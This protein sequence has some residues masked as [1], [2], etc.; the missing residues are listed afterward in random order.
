M[1]KYEYKGNELDLFEYA[2]NW[3]SYWSKQILPYIG[4][5]VLEVGAGIGSNTK[6]LNAGQ[7]KSWVCIEPDA[8]LV[9]EMRKKVCIGMLPKTLEIR[10]IS[11]NE[12][13]INEKFDTILY[14]DVL[15]HIKDDKFELERAFQ[16]LAPKGNIIILSPAHNFLY[17]EFDR[18]IE[19]YRRYNKKMLR[20]IIPDGIRIKLMRYIDAVGLF[21][22]LANKL[23]LRSA[24]PTLTQIKI[25]DSFM[26]TISRFVDP[27]LRH[28]FGKSI[29]CIIGGDKNEQPVAG[30]GIS[31]NGVI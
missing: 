23:V 12:L 4:N 16:H 28:Q 6:I 2:S 15:E 18:K 14:I 17:S 9:G 7:Y 5:S 25:W 3:K 22:S 29:I 31:K 13:E 24:D 21:A 19:H 11:I 1:N 8:K 30:C 20:S 26:V 10:P 27:L